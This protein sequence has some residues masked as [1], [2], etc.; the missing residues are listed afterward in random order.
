[1]KKIYASF[2][3][4]FGTLGIANAQVIL[5]Q[6][7]HAPVA[8]DSIQ[9][10]QI[11]STNVMPGAA[12][13]GAVWNFTATPTRTT[14][15]IDNAFTTSSS[16]LYPSATTVRNNNGSKAYYSSSG[17][18]YDFWG[19][20]FSALS[21]NIDYY[22]A[23]P[24]IQAKYPL[25]YNTNSATSTF[26]GN[27]KFGSST[28]TLTSGTSTVI[29]DGE[30]TLNLPARSFANALRVY[31]YVGFNYA[32]P[33]GFTTATGYVKQETWDYYSNLTEWP[34]AK[35]FPLFSI[36]TATVAV[37]SPTSVVQTSTLV[38][39]NRDYKLVGISETINESQGLSVYPNPADLNLNIELNN[40][41][42]DMISF[43]IMNSLGQVIRKENLGTQKGNVKYNVNV[44][45]IPAGIYFVKVAS[46][47][48]VSIKKI[49]IQ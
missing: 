47:E 28:G 7:N 23:T 25:A 24:A 17:T 42:S 30:G 39:L 4:F 8:G 9:M 43:E 46:G 35:S 13:T 49:T 22:F 31:N 32:V 6:S 11:D 27:L 37:T 45:D 40:K 20:N 18:E 41:G 29:A 3:L 14:I 26:T 16:T 1:M 38:M 48:N 10:W 36:V 15:L 5:A 34:F 21:Q 12:G 19:G 33:F 2:I 44:Q